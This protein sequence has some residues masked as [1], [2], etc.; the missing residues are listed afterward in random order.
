MKTSLC[1][2]PLLLALTACGLA[3][4]Q[5]FSSLQE[6][7]SAADFQKAGL[8][9]LTPEQLHFLNAWLRTHVGGAGNV[10]A[11]A[12]AGT[13]PVVV[14]PA[15]RFGYRA[16]VDQPRSTVASTLIGSFSGWDSHTRLS[17]ANG[18]LWQVSE[19]GSWSCQS[20]KDPK[21]T[22]KPMLLGSWLAYIQGCSNSVRV[23]RVR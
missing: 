20:L 4:A 22:I 17:L 14:G 3:H 9:K 5:S 11:G 8:D 1:L 16:P 12:G 21:V 19:S 13:A 15:N 7:M 23:E 18:Q 10:G 6:R 2:L